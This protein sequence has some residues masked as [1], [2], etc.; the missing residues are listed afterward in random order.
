MR[1]Q[2]SISRKHASQ[3]VGNTPYISDWPYPAST[4]NRILFKNK[5]FSL[6][7]IV[8]RRSLAQEPAGSSP[9]T[10]SSWRFRLGLQSSS[11]YS[12][13]HS[14]KPTQNAAMLEELTRNKPSHR[15]IEEKARKQ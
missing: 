10:A 12:K 3:T 15:C 11:L 8:I 13:K 6:A 2:G 9:T 4:D 1:L 14:C 5:E 7:F